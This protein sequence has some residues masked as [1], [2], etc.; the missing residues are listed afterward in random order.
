MAEGYVV[1]SEWTKNMLAK[2]DALHEA[3]LI[4]LLRGEPGT[5]KTTMVEQIAAAKNLHVEKPLGGAMEATDM[6]G[7]PVRVQRED[8]TWTTEYGTP[9]WADRAIN[10]D[11]ALVF[12]DEI[13]T[14]DP[15]VQ[16]SLLTILQSREVPMGPKIPDSVWFVAAANDTDA[17][18]N[19]WVLAP[20][21]ANRLCHVKWDPP[22]EDW[23]RGMVAAWGQEVS[24]EEADVRRQIAG[25]I[26]S[27]THML[28]D[29]PSDDDEAGAAWPSRRSW[30]NAARAMAF[31]PDDLK[32]DILAGFVG[33]SA[34]MQYASWE[35]MSDIPSSAEILDN[36]S[37][38]DWGSITSDITFAVIGGVMAAGM[39]ND[40]EKVVKVFIKAAESGFTDVVAGLVLDLLDNWPNGVKFPF[41][42]MKPFEQIIKTSGMI[43]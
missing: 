28:H 10:A 4:P 23:I 2:L 35:E 40:H 42:L 16:A 32:V 34:A 15:S 8:G 33:M 3:N 37:V 30:D 31:A 6:A 43:K 13:N 24:S 5:G 38:L 20:A 14:A 36:P 1:Q 7:L 25:F 27:M 18:A 9:G 19:G 26:G 41:S 29:R 12:M 21:L 17:T 22:A 39:P 11:A